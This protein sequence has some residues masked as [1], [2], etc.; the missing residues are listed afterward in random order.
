MAALLL[1]LARPQS[2]V[3]AINL[4]QSLHGAMLISPWVSFDTTYPSY[5]RN[6]KTDYLSARAIN[7]A[8]H[9][10]IGLGNKHD[11]YSQ[12]ILADATWWKQV[13]SSVVERM[14]I[15]CGGGEILQDGIHDFSTTVQEGFAQSEVNF[16]KVKSHG[17][18]DGVAGDG[19]TPK[20]NDRVTLIET[21]KCA[22]EEMIIDLLVRVRGKSRRGLAAREVEAW[23]E[24]NIE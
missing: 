2:L 14:M 6:A 11:E 9:A 16:E 4:T 15:W 20:G 12:P 1:H 10:F 7:R 23:L 8:S 13:G 5:T 21:P 17:S 24:R 22:H 18:A 19:D 3:P